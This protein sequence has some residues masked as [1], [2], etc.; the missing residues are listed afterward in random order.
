VTEMP[1]RD[2]REDEPPEVT[3]SGGVTLRAPGGGSGE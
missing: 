2:E 3:F 1:E